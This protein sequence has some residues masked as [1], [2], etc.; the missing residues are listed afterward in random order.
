MSPGLRRYA[1][2]A[3]AALHLAVFLWLIDPWR[4]AHEPQPEVALPVTLVFEAPPKP[5][6]QPAAPRPQPPK[7]PEEPPLYR[8]SGPDTKTTAPPQP[9]EPE[10]LKAEAKPAPAGTARG[11]RRA[12]AGPPRDHPDAADPAGL[13]A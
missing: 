8:E 1:I 2:A 7:P 6:P 10:P 4:D 5:T 3:A 13:K 11:A 12:A 9:P